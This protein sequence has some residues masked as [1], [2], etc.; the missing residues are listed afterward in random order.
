MRMNIKNILR[1]CLR[2]C[3]ECEWSVDKSGEV[4]MGCD[5]DK[6]CR[7][8]E[9]ELNEVLEEKIDECKDIIE[10]M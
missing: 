7:V 6:I 1:E 4:C 2:E 5:N 3:R 9:K 8:F 10:V